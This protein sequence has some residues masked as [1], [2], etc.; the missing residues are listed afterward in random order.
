VG[1]LLRAQRA[2]AETVQEETGTI[3]PRVFHRNGEPFASFYKQ[4]RLACVKVGLG[5]V[6]P[7]T[8]GKIVKRMP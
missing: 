2:Y 8:K 3:I 4:W 6:A 5:Y 7:T 1:S